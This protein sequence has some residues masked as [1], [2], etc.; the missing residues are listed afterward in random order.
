MFYGA[1]SSLVIESP[2]VVGHQ[3]F[4]SPG[5]LPHQ[6]IEARSLAL[7]ADSLLTVPREAPRECLTPIQ[8]M[9]VENEE[10]SDE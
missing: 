3:P 6:S 9:H 2:G 5:D 4:P 10:Y 7:Q 8:Q 1:W